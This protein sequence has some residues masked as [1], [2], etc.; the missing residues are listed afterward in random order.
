MHVIQ[1]TSAAD[2]TTKDLIQP[3]TCGDEEKNN[4]NV[5][6]NGDYNDA[7]FLDV[8]NQNYYHGFNREEQFIK[9]NIYTKNRD[10]H[11]ETI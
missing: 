7:D 9:N 2:S 1:V 6:E 11:V 4:N 10:P 5:S 8:Q 3:A